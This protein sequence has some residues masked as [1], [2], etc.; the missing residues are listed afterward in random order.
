MDIEIA[1]IDVERLIRVLHKNLNYWQ[2]LK[3]FLSACL[4]LQM[5]ADTEFWVKQK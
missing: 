4:K 2:I 1:E 3:I 5:L